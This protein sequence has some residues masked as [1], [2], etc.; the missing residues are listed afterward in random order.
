MENLHSNEE[1]LSNGSVDITILDSGEARDYIADML[2]SGNLDALRA[3]LNQVKDRY[4]SMHGSIG[5]EY[6]YQYY[7]Y[8]IV[9]LSEA[10]GIEPFS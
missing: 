8:L 4:D 9:E 3:S 6:E 1:G 2:A 7:I 5:G 10:L